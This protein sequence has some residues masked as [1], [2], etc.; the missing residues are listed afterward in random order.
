MGLPALGRIE[1]ARPSVPTL[2]K[3]STTLNGSGL[4]EMY[5]TGS[6]ASM[7]SD[8][9]L[10]LTRELMVFRRTPLVAAG[11]SAAD[12]AR[13]ASTHAKTTVRERATPLVTVIPWPQAIGVSC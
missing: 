4:V 5:G 1:L 2:R 11:V 6:V 8:A 9:P 12:P 13:S 3:S 10:E 7:T